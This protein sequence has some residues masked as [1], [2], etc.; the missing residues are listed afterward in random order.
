MQQA[1]GEEDRH[2]FLPYGAYSLGTVPLKEALFHSGFWSQFLPCLLGL[3][4]EFGE[5]V[6]FYT[7]PI[8]TLTSVMCQMFSV[9]TLTDS[10]LAAGLELRQ[11]FSE[12]KF[13]LKDKVN[14]M[15][16]S[17]GD[18]ITEYRRLGGL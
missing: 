2:D 7:I 6:R 4:V 3:G 17:I 1:Q 16:Q 10:K 9:G 18:A 8:T 5:A 11:G 13:A 15:S 12:V 14:Q